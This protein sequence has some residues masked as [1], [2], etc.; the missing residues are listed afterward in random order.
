MSCK[1][2]IYKCLENNYVNN[3][4]HIVSKKSLILVKRL[5]C[6][7]CK[8]CGGIIEA[9]NEDLWNASLDISTCEHGELYRADV[10]ITSTDWE[11]G[12]ADDWRVVFKRT[13]I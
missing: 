3:K 4:G 11:T 9:I 13:L 1:G 7:G 5:S 12:F 2:Q 6:K 10:E 8:E